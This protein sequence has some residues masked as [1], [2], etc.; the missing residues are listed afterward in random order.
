MMPNKLKNELNVCLLNNKC[1][2]F[3]QIYLTIKDNFSV[4]NLYEG[5]NDKS[6]D[7]IIN[8]QSGIVIV[9]LYCITNLIEKMNLEGLTLGEDIPVML[10]LKRD[11]SI[12]ATI[13]DSKIIK[14]IIVLPCSMQEIIDQIEFV[15]QNVQKNKIKK[16]VETGKG[17]QTNND[18]IFIEKL[19]GIILD[20]MEKGDVT[21]NTIA[22]KMGKTAGKLNDKLKGST[23]LSA[24]Q[25]ILQ[26]RLKIAKNLLE[27]NKFNVQEVAIKTCF[28][29][30]SYFTKAFKGYFGV[31][32]SKHNNTNYVYA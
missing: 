10:F 14:N 18:L 13:L 12:T 4:V 27:Q 2:L 26:Y 31:L 20:Q 19:E 7:K 6:L 9:D 28:L 30:V 16:I 11:E 15:N 17:N 3:E 32:P 21:V 22:I 23:G 25:F 8:Q 29:S 1:F 5:F 24:V